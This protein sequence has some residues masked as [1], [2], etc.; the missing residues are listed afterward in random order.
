MPHGIAMSS[1]RKAFPVTLTDF[2]N[3]PLV[4]YCSQIEVSKS[5]SPYN[6]SYGMLLKYLSVF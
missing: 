6:Y 4:L 3:S 1:N 5:E 2:P